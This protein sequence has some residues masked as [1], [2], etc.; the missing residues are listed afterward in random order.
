[1]ERRPLDGI[2][3]ESTPG[4]G[5][6]TASSIFLNGGRAPDSWRALQRTVG[7]APAAGARLQPARRRK[8]QTAVPLSARGRGDAPR[9]QQEDLTGTMLGGPG[10]KPFETTL[11]PNDSEHSEPNAARIESPDDHE[12]DGDKPS[13]ILHA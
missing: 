13:K 8:P 2:A 4:G 10:A 9:T 1:M 5:R 12:N 6:R 7:P 11:K 3:L